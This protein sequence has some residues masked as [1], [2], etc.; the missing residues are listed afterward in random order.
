[1]SFTVRCPHCDIMLKVP[2]KYHYQKITCPKCNRDIEAISA[3]TLEV[4][5][6]FL[7][8]LEDM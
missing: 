7:K 4:G 1:V 8:Q 2:D 5:K 6:E 3:E